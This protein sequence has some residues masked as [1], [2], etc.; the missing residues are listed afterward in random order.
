MATKQSLLLTIQANQNVALDKI[1]E[2]DAGI[3]ALI[4]QG[5]GGGGTTPSDLDDVEAALNTA[6]GEVV[7]QIDLLKTQLPGN[8]T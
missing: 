4:A 3:K 5:G 8:N 6:Q 1:K 7:K 2:V